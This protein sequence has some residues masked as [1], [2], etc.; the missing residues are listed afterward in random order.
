MDQ[1]AT[2]MAL[3]AL[4]T[5]LGGRCPRPAAARRDWRRL[6]RLRAPGFAAGPS[7][8]LFR[9]CTAVVASRRIV[10]YVSFSALG[11]R[12]RVSRII[13]PG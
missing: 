7:V 10:R 11:I 3:A 12:R 13:V 1:G 5:G 8:G 2:E 9:T 4:E 6:H